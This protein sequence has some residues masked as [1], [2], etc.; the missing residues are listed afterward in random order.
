VFFGEIVV[1]G[2]FEIMDEDV[3]CKDVW[4]KGEGEF[5]PF[6]AVGVGFEVYCYALRV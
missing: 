1:C 2:V 4:L 5:I 6:G 3:G